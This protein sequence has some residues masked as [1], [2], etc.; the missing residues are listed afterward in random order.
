[1][2]PGKP[3]PILQYAD[4]IIRAN[5]AEVTHLKRL[6][7]QFSE[8]TGLHI[9]YTKSTMVP[10]HVP[11]DELSTELRNILGEFFILILLNLI[12]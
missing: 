9:N 7:D 3:C 12:F 4:Q 2:V 10:M 11:E 8:A 5:A 1:L 6:L